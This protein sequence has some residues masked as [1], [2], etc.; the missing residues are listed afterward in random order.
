[1]RDTRDQ[2]IDKY[3]YM[4][5]MVPLFLLYT[6]KCEFTLGN[7]HYGPQTASDKHAFF[8]VCHQRAKAR[9]T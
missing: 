9:Q 1:M 2:E 8:I 3:F 6:K 4:C 7:Y 5:I